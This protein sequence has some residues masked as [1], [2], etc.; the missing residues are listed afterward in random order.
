MSIKSLF[1]AVVVVAGFSVVTRLMGFLFRIYLSREL[2]AELLGVYQS[3]FAI[4]S[5][6]LVMISSGLPLAVSKLV[7]AHGGDKRQEYRVVS[8]ALILGILTAL[9]LGGIVLLCRQWLGFLF[10][11]E[12]CVLILITLLPALVSSAIYSVLRGDFWGERDYYTVGWTELVEQVLRILFFVILINTG[13]Y[14]LD[15]AGIAGVSM[16]IACVLS[17]VLVLFVY[18]KKG[19]RLYAPK[20]EFR[21]VL[22]SAVPVTGIRAVS[23]LIHPLIAVIFPLLLVSVGYTQSQAMESYGIAMGMTFPLL[24]VPST[25]VGALS[26]TLIPEL[27]SALSGRK[28]ELVAKRVQTSCIVAVFVS[29][30]FIPMYVG[31]GELIGKVLYNNVTSGIYLARASWIMI[32]LSLSNITSSVLNA[33]NLETKSF[34]NN[35]IGGIALLICVV[36]FSG[37]IGVDALI[38]GFGL[39]M[40]L[41]TIINIYTIKK[42]TK[43]SFGITKSILYMLALTIPC[44]L[45]VMW[46]E[47]MLLRVVPDWL[48][49]CV[50]S[51]LSIG[52]YVLCCWGARL[53]DVTSVFIKLKRQ[54]K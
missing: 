7:S 47:P 1:H 9:T 41:T 28:I 23:S 31:G 24:F 46:S 33:F 54:N 27:S 52:G 13:F 50:L 26:F 29:A 20:G 11:D 15:G 3:A 51:A 17:A 39:C 21:P 2:G 40:I 8:V 6:L 5:V 48:G 45:L 43:L 12:R 10:T 4:F 30:M 53:V 22:R 34:V 16:S 49:M 36:C 32:P 37:S 38:W 14:A 25:V 18:F 35:I 44:T 42:H 19:K